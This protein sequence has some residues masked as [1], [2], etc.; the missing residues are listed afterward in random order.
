MTSIAANTQDSGVTGWSA[1]ASVFFEHWQSLR[2]GTNAPTSEAFLDAPNPRVQ[3]NTFI[4]E[5]VDDDRTVF[6]LVGTEIFMIWGKDFTKLS[7]EEAFSAELAAIYLA[8]PRACIPNTCGLWEQ[9]VFGD[10]R[11][12]EVILELIY[13]PLRVNSGRP[14]RLGGFLNCH[15]T[16]DTP[17]SRIGLIALTD[18]KWID[19]GAGI[20]DTPPKI[21]K[22]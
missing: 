22:A 11:G 1:R 9:G 4:F 21:F 13:L 17:A 6:R 8:A 5:L 10:T 15:G 3:A 12:R 20:P 19:I 18:R 7:V 16:S 14:A 2:S